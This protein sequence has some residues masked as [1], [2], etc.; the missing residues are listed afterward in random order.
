MLPHNRQQISN[1]RHSHTTH[2]KNVLYYSVMLE[3]KLTQGS[4]DTFVRDVKAALSPQSILFFDWQL[5]DMEHFL[6]NNRQ[7]GV[8]TV[9]TT[10]NLGEFYVTVVT[11]PQLMLQD[12]R[13]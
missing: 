7:F 12:V 10:F 8:L 5:C 2:D 4:N 3:C 13:T 11:Y 6:S 1:V 9:D